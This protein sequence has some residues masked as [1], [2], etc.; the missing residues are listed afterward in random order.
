MS[1]AEFSGLGTAPVVDQ[2]STYD[3]VAKD[4][5][6]G[7][8]STTAA[9]EL[10]I[11]GFSVAGPLSDNFTA[12]T[13]NG[14][15][16]LGEDGT[17]NITIDAEWKAVTTTGA[18]SADGSNSK[19]RKYAGA[20]VTYAPVAVLDQAHYRWRENDDTESAAAWKEDQD[21][22]AALGRGYAQRIRFLVENEGI[23][24]SGGVAY[25]LE[26]AEITEPDTCADGSYSFVPTDTSGDWQ[27]AAS[28]LVEGAITTNIVGSFTKPGG[29]IWVD[30]EQRET[31]NTT[32]SI[33]L[34]GDEFT[35]IEF[36][37]KT[38]STVTYGGDYCFRL[39]AG[40]APLDKYSAYAEAEVRC[41]FE[42]RRLLTVDK[43][44]V[45]VDNNPG[46]LSDYPV[47]VHLTGDWL[48]TTTVDPTNGRIEDVNGYDIVFR[49]DGGSCTS[50]RPCDA[51]DFEIEKYNG[52]DGELIAWVRIPSLSKSADTDFYIYYGNVCVSDD[53]QNATGVWNANYKGVWHL[54]EDPEASAPQFLDSTTNPNDGTANSLA[55]ANQVA[56]QIDGSLEFDD[57]SERHVSVSDHSSLQLSTN[58]TISVWLNT[59]DT[60]TDTAVIVN[61]WSSGTSAR[62]YWLGKW[63][64]NSLAFFVDDTQTVTAGLS[65]INDGAWHHVTG[66]ADVANSLLR[67]YVDGLEKNTTSYSGTSRT[68]TNALHIGHGSG[69][70][71]QE[72]DGIIDEVRVSSIVRTADWIQTDYSNQ[73]D[74]TKAAGCTDN[75]FICMGSEETDPATAVSLISFTARGQGNAVAIEWETAAEFDNIGF[76]LYRASSPGGPYSRLTDK[77]ISARPRQGRGANYSFL[78]SDVAVGSLYYYKLE[79][80]DVYGKH[81]MHG[82]ISV[83]WDADDL[84]DDWEI[85]HGLNPWVN[86]ADLDHD[87]DGLSNFEEYERNLDPFNPDTDGDGILDGAEDGRLPVPEDNGSHS[88]SR[89]V[90][91][92]AA[93][94]SGMTIALNTSGFEAEVITV[95]GAEYERLYIGDYVHGYTHRVGAPQLPLKGLLID[96]PAGKAAELAVLN[97][98]AEPYSGYRIYPVPQTVL[99]AQ[100]GMA[101]VGTAFVQDDLAYSS[102]GLYPQDAALLGQSYVFRDQLKQQV[103]FYPLRFNPASGQL[104]LYRRIELRIDFVDARYAQVS[105]PVQMP[106]QPPQTVGDVLSS[107]AMG[108]AATPVLVNPISPILSSLGAT[109]AA[110][111]SPPESADGNVYKI[112]TDAE[113]I[114][115]IT[116]DYL[117]TNGVDTDGIDLSQVRIYYLGQEVAIDVFDQNSDD[118]FD[119]A[120][121]ITFYARPVS[122]PYAKYSAENV[123][124]MTLSGGAGLPKRMAT[125]DGSPAGGA[126]ATDFM[127][128]ARHEQDLMYWLRAPGADS[129]E[130]WFFN[131]FVQGTEHAGGGLPKSFTITVPEPVSTGTLTI[132]VAGQTDTDHE[133]R[134]AINGSEQSFMW[135]GISYY[136]ATLDN[137]AL[138]AGDNTVTLQCLSAD[139]NDSMAVDWFEVAYRR[140][141]VAAANTLKFSPDSGSRY[142]IDDFTDNNLLSFD[143]SDPTNV[144]KIDNAII[145]GTNPYSFEFEPTTAGSAY[146]VLASEVS[147]IP[148]GLIED[149]AADLAHNAS[150]ADY[151]L[152]THRDLGWDQNGDQL[153]WL[154]D[155]VAHRQ[156]QGLRVEVVDIEDVYDEFSYGIKSPRALKDFLAYA[157]SNWQAPAPQYVLLAGD[158]TYD[159][160]D[161]WNGADAT[162]YLPTYLMFTDYKGETVTDQWFVTV[163]GDDAVADMHIGRLPAADAA[164][165][166]V[167]VSK[168]LT[169]ETTPNSKFSDPNAW[170]KNILLVADNQR[171][172][173]DYLYEADFATMNEDAA[174]ML[175]PIMNPYAGYL[176]IHYADAAY[177]TDFITTTLNTEGALMVNFAGHGGTQ[178]WAEEHI[179]DTGDLAGLTNAAELPFFVSMSCETGF[180]AYPEV[181]FYPSLAEALLRSD[182]GAVAALMPTGMTTTEG[183]RILNSA[184]FEQIF[185]EDIR[186]LGPAIA[187]AKQTLL[188]NGAEYEQASQTFLLFGDPA[189]ALKVPQPRM[190]KE[191]QIQWKKDGPFIQW[192]AAKDSN[193][194]PVAGYNVYR[195]LSAGGIYTRINSA[196]ITATQYLD[197]GSA[198]VSAQSTAGSSAANYYYGVTSVDSSGDESAQTLG[199]SPPAPES[200]SDYVIIP[201]CFI[202]TATPAAEFKITFKALVVIVSI[203]LGFL[204]LQAIV[205]PQRKKNAAHK[206]MNPFNE[207]KNVKTLLVDDDEFIRDSL[208]MAFAN[209]GCSLQLAETAEEGL[210]AI[211]DQQFD[212]IISDLRL[213]GMNGLDFLKLTA[214]T[215]PQAVKFLITAYRD[216]HIFSEAIRL[217]VHEFIEKPFAVKVLINL[218]ALSIKR[219][220][221]RQAVAGI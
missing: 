158:S 57:T 113:G 10:L 32:G 209:N 195:S 131:I 122:S 146:L 31:S 205:K 51:L 106:W 62:N 188:A 215:Q 22:K 164:Q 39:T 73:Y 95:G 154:T 174:A 20:I 19:T 165:A 157:Y 87:G 147:K 217:G 8:A 67:I 6:S 24:S 136:E 173:A 72:F 74:P 134:V 194:N 200:K 105:P 220:A 44:Q 210:L 115:R 88:I 153:A 144:V 171:V 123:Y 177:L 82:P 175:P 60:Q 110:L 218:L 68:G 54:K 52:T 43:D 90:E 127:D 151:I 37:I 133:L 28:Q 102:D 207:L 29:Y 148:V 47:L 128:T 5:T 156:D 17:S 96:V 178:V 216:D 192:Q 203:I 49:Y 78:D 83:D 13:G 42:Y 84:P 55:I 107:M 18:Y 99:D 80:I 114:Y 208:G 7:S 198:G 202:T 138:F 168:I 161:H 89:G 149:T 65:L 140:E 3:G 66:V 108:F 145:T 184:L 100:D 206:K 204:L 75:G 16:A 1:V 187:A 21:T 23:Q 76:H 183:Q 59:S 143:I 167:M 190:P 97:S 129:I 176:G 91:V 150:G 103:T 172:G 56:G 179:L 121:Y 116:K 118:H 38:T 152:I 185:S 2:T 94:E 58:M 98:A 132:L 69:E 34:A 139:G 201:G 71:S 135:S 50:G 53:S 36:S 9:I 45:G 64:E 182:A 166:A 12:D 101:A 11:G 130:R 15:A 124:W 142:N 33:T 212:I 79:D 170:E 193:N 180:F 186:I 120:D 70:V 77:L 63:D 196:L 181:W 197:S 199:V 189:M 25:Q 191:V 85:T 163:S 126:L 159:P 86:D 211:Q 219:Q 141:Y 4:F 169:Y 221:R 14:W 125:D 40:G 104:I 81:T 160:K 27:M 137:V 92:L 30:G 155:L 117:D 46:T 119:A 35:E 214:V 48:K 41:N 162:A 61:K 112:L 26:V 111:W 213:P 109:V 93:D